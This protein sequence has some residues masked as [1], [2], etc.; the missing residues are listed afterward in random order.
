LPGSPAI[1]AGNNNGLYQ[2]EQRGRGYPRTSGA[3]AK[4]DIGAVQ[5]DSIFFDDFEGN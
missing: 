5:F 1:G 2:V 3:A 4:V